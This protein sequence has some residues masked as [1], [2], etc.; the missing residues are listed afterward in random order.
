MRKQ[1]VHGGPEIGGSIPLLLDVILAYIKHHLKVAGHNDAVTLFS[2]GALKRIA[3][4]SQGYD[5]HFRIVRLSPVY[6]AN[7]Y[8]KFRGNSQ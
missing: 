5:R 6:P 4:W 3:E 7:L 8:V 2:D 1:R